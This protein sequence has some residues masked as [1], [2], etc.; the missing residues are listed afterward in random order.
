MARD[1]KPEPPSNRRGDSNFSWP[2]IPENEA[3]VKIWN[4]LPA[5]VDNQGVRDF[6]DDHGVDV[7]HRDDFRSAPELG[8]AYSFLS[9][10]IGNSKPDR[11]L[12]ARTVLTKGGKLA[13]KFANCMFIAHHNFEGELIGITAGR[14]NRDEN[15]ESEKPAKYETMHHHI[16]T[17][18]PWITGKRLVIPR[19]EVEA[20]QGYSDPE[21]S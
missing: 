4:H 17:W 13:D 12:L 9:G 10:K 3:L 8:T 2:R 7:K 18:L 5:S 1:P 6:L 14:I 21:G 15:D 16:V 11:K 19:W 20:L